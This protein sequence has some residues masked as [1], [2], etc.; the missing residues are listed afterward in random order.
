MELLFSCIALASIA[1]GFFSLG[2]I[3]GTRFPLAS[4][5][6]CAFSLIFGGLMCWVAGGDLR[7]AL[8]SPGSVANQMSYSPALLVFCAAGALS[9]NQTVRA[10]SRRLLS[11][12]LCVTVAGLFGA[13]LMRPYC[14][15]ILLSQH[16]LWNGGVCLQSHESSCVPAAASNLLHM[17]GI[18]KG[19]RELADFARTSVDGTSPLGSF[20]AVSQAVEGTDLKA[21]IQL[22]RPAVN[23]GQHLPIL[24]HVRFDSSSESGLNQAGLFSRF[25]RGIRTRSEGHAVVIVE[26]CSAGWIVA[27]PAAG[28]VIWSNQHLA[29]SWSGEGVY[30]CPK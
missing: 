15:P 5:L 19:E 10:G 20:L 2:R 21:F 17:H 28:K 4:S 27:D 14:R 30:L 22:K 8:W 7:W 6:I 25:L 24:A 12:A 23:I 9:V 1:V 13:V 11:G 29:E 16:S 3:L 18:D 26:R